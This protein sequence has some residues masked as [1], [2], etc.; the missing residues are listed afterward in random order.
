MMH[1]SVESKVNLINQE[2]ISMKSKYRKSY[3]WENNYYS[4]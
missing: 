3:S 4:Y 2:D 1:N